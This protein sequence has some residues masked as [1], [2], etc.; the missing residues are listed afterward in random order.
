MILLFRLRTDHRGFTLVELSIV[1]VVISLLLVALLGP[2]AAQQEQKNIMEARRQMDE[3]REALFGFL[4]SNG[5]LPC[6]A[7]P[8]L[9]TSNINAGVERVGG[10]TSIANSVG[11]LPW[12]TLGVRETD[13]WGNRFT[14]RVTQNFAS[15]ATPIV[16]TPTPTNGDIRVLQSAGGANSVG[17]NEVV[18][19]IV[20]HG[21]HSAGAWSPAGGAQS[22]A[23]SDPDEIEN[24][25]GDLTFV[26]HSNTAANPNSPYD[27]LVAW[28]PR[29]LVFNKLIMVGRLP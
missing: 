22:A 19:I 6:P 18:A 25:N 17:P 7:D 12:R 23:G 3:A 4:S 9:V 8:T 26:D 16:L 1:L 15:S 24:S 28:I 29:A 14:Y 27:D 20:S 10:C 21:H 5:R 2:L 11:V 13:P